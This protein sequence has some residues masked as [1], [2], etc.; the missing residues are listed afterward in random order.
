MSLVKKCKTCKKEKELS[1]FHY[2]PYKTNKNYSGSCKICNLERAKRRLQ[3]DPEKRKAA[4]Q[5]SRLWQKKNRKRYK[6]LLLKNCFGITEEFYNTLKKEQND[7]C[8]ICKR[9]ETTITKH[10]HLK[11][12]AVDHDHSTGKIRGLLCGSCNRGIGFL[13]DSPDVCISAADYLKRHS[14]EKT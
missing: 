12:L 3:E 13:K 11:D 7:V 9:P 8:A 4:N 2:T 6:Y 5:S 10:G 14:E 1:E